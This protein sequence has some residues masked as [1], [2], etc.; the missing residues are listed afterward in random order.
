MRPVTDILVKP[1]GP[2][3]NMDCGYCFYSGRQELYAG[4]PTRMAPDVLERMIQ[5]IMEQEVDQVS[6]GWQGG[7]PTLMGLPFYQK[8]VDLMRRYGKGKEV[9]N[10]LQTNG[11][12]LDKGWARFFKKY[13]FLV[14]LSLDGPEHV[15]D[16]YRRLR[17]GQPTWS[18]V[19]DGARLLLDR[20]VEVNA[21]AVVNRYSAGFPE[22]IY[23]F[24]RDMGLTYMQFIPCVESDPD[25][26]G[27]AAPFSVTAEQYGPFLC[28]VFDRW[29]SDF[30]NGVPMTS[31]RFFESLLF[32]YAGFPSPE[33]TLLPECGTYVVVEH[34]G[35]VY[36]C[37]FFVEG[38][39]K[40]G[41]LIEDSLADCLNSE[42]QKLFGSLKS[43]LHG[44]CR[45]CG[46]RELCRGGCTKDRVRVAA[47]G[48]L[49]HFCA[50]F[51]MFFRH[52]DPHF[53]R[54]AEEWRRKQ[55]G[56]R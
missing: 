43:N 13:K 1:A 26:P 47:D 12:L 53:R 3:C 35:D 54:L 16:H 9:A 17:G 24:L 23:D 2:D 52:A 10:G 46:W 28:T 29:I 38:E 33:C 19:A 51:K 56:V 48:N 31:V 44:E 6:I 18:R 27:E 21:L 25:R 30:K 20:G 4:P 39:W 41:N 36:S 37:D 50:A 45:E 49:N 14:G 42:R 32:C 11:L 15:H 34:N 22:E 7:E 55:A 8:A 40:L 5:Q